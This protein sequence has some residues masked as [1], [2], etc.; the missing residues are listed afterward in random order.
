[1]QIKIPYNFSQ[2]MYDYDKANHE[3]VISHNL[4]LIIAFITLILNQVQFKTYIIELAFVRFK[5]ER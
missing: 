1:M 4:L 2:N 5:R 3:V